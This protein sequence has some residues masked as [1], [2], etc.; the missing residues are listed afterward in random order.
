[1][2]PHDD[3]ELNVARKGQAFQM[4]SNIFS[5]SHSGLAENHGVAS[6]ILAL[7]TI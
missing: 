1:M 3:C 5:E 2:T 7:G 6:S 4:R